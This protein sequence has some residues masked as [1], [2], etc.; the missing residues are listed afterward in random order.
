[1]A[2]VLMREHPEFF[3][4]C[5]DLEPGAAVGEEA[6]LT[7]PWEAFSGEAVA[8]SRGG[9]LHAPRLFRRRLPVS[10]PALPLRRDGAYLIT[11]GLGGAGL[12]TAAWMAERGAGHLF[13]MGR[14]APSEAAAERIAGMEAMG[15][16]VTPLCAD[17][18]D[19][20]SLDR[21]LAEAAKEKKPIR[22]VVHTAGVFEDS[23]LFR[24]RWDRFERVLSAKVTGGWNLYRRF[25]KAELDF[26]LLFSSATVL[27]PTPGLSNYTAANAFLDLLAHRLRAE[28][29]PAVSIAWGPWEETGMAREVGKLRA[30]QWSAAGLKA[31]P[32]GRML[33]SMGALLGEKIAHAAVMDVD[34]RRCLPHQPADLVRGF[35][36]R[37]SENAAG[38]ARQPGYFASELQG[39]APDARMERLRRHVTEGVLGVTGLDPSRLDPAV[40]L[41]QQ[42]LDSLTSMELR[43]S[44]QESLGCTLET[45]VIFRYPTVNALAA[46]LFDRILGCGDAVTGEPPSD[47]PISEGIRQAAEACSGEGLASAIEAELAGLES[48]L[49][50]S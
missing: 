4:Q 19:A 46:Y 17:V 15:T 16:K 12:E 50:R 14:S 25:R 33:A 11:G 5:L 42:G 2:A 40:G 45:T 41:F 32:P 22:G 48:L 24:H 27:I 6:L 34:W 29:I 23:L 47:D 30:A 28:G 20:G 49:G 37:L 13:L 38:S 39:V 8:A 3:C 31:T 43:M 35:Y 1:M 10:A 36:R 7:A 18:A 44:L 26:M 21:A 9:I